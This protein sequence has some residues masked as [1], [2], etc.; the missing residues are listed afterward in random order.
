[1]FLFLITIRLV[2]HIFICFNRV[3]ILLVSQLVVLNISNSARD[4][5][6]NPSRANC[7]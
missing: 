4:G 6:N 7:Q 1:M 3:T 2:Y 5:Y